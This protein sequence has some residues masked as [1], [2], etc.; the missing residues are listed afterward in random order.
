MLLGEE[1]LLS[2]VGVG[3]RNSEPSHA[4]CT[5]YHRLRRRRSTRLSPRLTIPT[6]ARCG[7]ATAPTEPLCR[8]LLRE[9]CRGLPAVLG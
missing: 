6:R 3:F 4:Y 1:A 9:G 8:C 7:C 5:G 2:F